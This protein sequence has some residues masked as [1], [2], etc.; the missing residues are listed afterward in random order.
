MR[1]DFVASNVD[2]KVRAVVQH[3]GRTAANILSLPDIVHVE[4]QALNGG[5]YAQSILSHRFRNRVVL[6][7][8]LSATEIMLPFVHE[9]IHVQQQHLGHLKCLPSGVI[10][11][12]GQHFSPNDNLSYNDYLALPW[13]CD[14]VAQQLP[15]FKRCI[16]LGRKNSDV[17]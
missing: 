1:I 10:V 8:H 11:W 15:I 7:S 6:N 16:D 13:E 3:L 2:I 14:A 5:V 9:L 4:F 17:L 12:K